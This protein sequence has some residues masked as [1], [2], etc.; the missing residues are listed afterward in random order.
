MGQGDSKEHEW[1]LGYASS[2]TDASTVLA[3]GLFM[4]SGDDRLDGPGVGQCPRLSPDDL[5]LHNGRRN[6]PRFARFDGRIVAR[7]GRLGRDDDVEMVRGS[8]RRGH[9][10]RGILTPRR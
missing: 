6:G 4:R 9:F 7:Y 3:T 10:R 5:I 2:W 8:S 1:T